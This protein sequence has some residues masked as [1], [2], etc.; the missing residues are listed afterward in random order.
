[1]MLHSVN[2]P[3]KTAVLKLT[4]SFSEFQT[5]IKKR[6]ANA[7]LEASMAHRLK[8]QSQQPRDA[9]GRYMRTG[10]GETWKI[11]KN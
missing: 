3:I 6:R 4:S 10:G 5:G 7:E 9:R 1:M 11:S 2:S 8:I